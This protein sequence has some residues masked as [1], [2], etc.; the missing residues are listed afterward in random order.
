M[1]RPKGVPHHLTLTDAD[2]ATLATALLNGRAS[3]A[4]LSR[5]LGKSYSAVV[6]MLRKLRRQGGWLEHISWRNCLDLECSRPVLTTP[7]RPRRLASLPPLC[8]RYCA[9]IRKGKKMPRPMY[10]E[11]LRGSVARGRLTGQARAK[12]SGGFRSR[13]VAPPWEQALVDLAFHDLA[14]DI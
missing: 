2:I 11:Q 14:Y 9:D 1:A 7:H 5:R 6:Q 13:V 8:T 10:W 4:E 3:V 12:R